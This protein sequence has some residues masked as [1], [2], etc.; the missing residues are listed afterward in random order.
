MV[1]PLKR[2]MLTSG[3]PCPYG[4]SYCFAKFP[5]YPRPLRLE[6]LEAD[7]FRAEAFDVIYPSCDT[8][9]F[10]H[11]EGLNILRRAAE[12]KKSLSVSTKAALDIETIQLLKSISDAL[13]EFG[14]VLK[15]GIS[16]STK[17]HILGIEPRTASYQERLENLKHLSEARVFCCAILKPI[18]AEISPLEYCEIL[19]DVSPYVNYVLIGGEYLQ[20]E[21]SLEGRSIEANYRAVN[22]IDNKPLWLFSESARHRLAIIK[23]AV[24][25]GM[26]WF[27]SD[28]ELIGHIL[29]NIG[30]VATH[31]L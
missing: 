6:A 27:E 4:C 31:R 9:L 14:S 10:S 22:W 19:E 8:D 12:F 24:D 20:N 26:R 23:K 17:H 28:L 2:L 7:P 3:R 29:S 15:I 11:R 5:Q 25:I 16:F 21:V 1:T 18:I 30:V 13:L